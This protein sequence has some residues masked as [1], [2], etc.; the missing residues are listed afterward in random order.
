MK[1]K[2]LIGQHLELDNNLLDDEIDEQPSPDK[3]H[4]DFNYLSKKYEKIVSTNGVLKKKV[5]SLTKDLDRFKKKK[6][7]TKEN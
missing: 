2:Y 3:L 5:L 6:Q 4:D 7:K 1:I